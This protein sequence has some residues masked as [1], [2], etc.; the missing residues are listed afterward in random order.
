MYLGWDAGGLAQ[1]SDFFL[2]NSLYFTR[3]RSGKEEHLN[4]MYTLP[5][6]QAPSNDLQEKLGP[7]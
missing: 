6:A 5:A 3:E 4:H 7:V 1:L 2:I